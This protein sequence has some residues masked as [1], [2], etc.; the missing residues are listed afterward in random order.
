MGCLVR[1]R[2]GDTSHRRVE[3]E[4]SLRRY[5]RRITADN[6]EPDMA[7]WLIATVPGTVLTTLIN[8]KVMPDPYFGMN[9][10][11]IPDVY[12][13]GRDYYTY[14]FFTRFSTESIDSTKQVWL[15]FRG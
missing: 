11:T 13:E 15:N 2:A 14:W 1:D 3:D 5:G 8:N 6:E 9:N 10:A 12:T 7:G 4:E